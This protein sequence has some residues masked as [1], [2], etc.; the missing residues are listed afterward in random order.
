MGWGGSSKKMTSLSVDALVEMAPKKSEGWFSKSEKPVGRE[1]LRKRRDDMHV[2]LKAE[3]K[4]EKQAL[5]AEPM[6]GP[7]PAESCRSAKVRPSV[8][9]LFFTR[10]SLSGGVKPRPTKSAG[11]ASKSSLFT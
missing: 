7:P 11:M 3:K 4:A 8:M 2:A 10:S 5:S 9:P 6:E 1:F